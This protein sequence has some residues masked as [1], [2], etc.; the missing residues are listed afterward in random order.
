MAGNR[1]LSENWLN[2][3]SHS[4]ITCHNITWVK[5]S[6]F[7]CIQTASD[8]YFDQIPVSG[9][10]PHAHDFLEMLLVSTG[11]LLHAVNGERQ[12]LTA[13]DVCFLRPD[14]V[15]HFAP[16]GTFEQVEVVMLDY[17]LELSLALSAYLGDDEFLHRMTASVLPACFKLDPAATTSLYERLIKLNTPANTARLRGIK[18]KI[19]LGELY[20]RFFVDDSSL[21]M[22]SRVPRWLETLCAAMRKPENFLGG[23]RRMQHLS[24]RTPGHL[25]KVFRQNL[26]KT[27]TEFINELRIN[28]AAWM[29]A[30]TDE[31]IV[32]IADELNFQSLSRFYHLFR[33]TYGVSPAAYRRLHLNNRQV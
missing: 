6:D 7:H 27:P 31:E 10:M 21:L 5:S 14:D 4:R 22:E 2:P 30:D 32:A 12:H 29:L 28:H 25:C 19:L 20:A 17:G 18:V 3:V 1:Q 8:L 26:H 15:H 9:T 23:V 11:G 24:R 13:G 33:Q 16:D